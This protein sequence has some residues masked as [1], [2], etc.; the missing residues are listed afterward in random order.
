MA[1]PSFGKTGLPGKSF[2]D[3]MRHIVWSEQPD[4]RPDDTSHEKYMWLLV[5]RFLNDINEYRDKYF[6]P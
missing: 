2:D 4:V 1:D 3:L 5:N 6:T